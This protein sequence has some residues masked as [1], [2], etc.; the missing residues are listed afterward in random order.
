MLWMD[1]ALLRRTRI[2]RDVRMRTCVQHQSNGG[3]STGVS[4][5]FQLIQ[6]VL[7]HANHCMHAWSAANSGFRV[8]ELVG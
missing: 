2:Q 6:G 7:G 5:H 3:N 4:I 1:S 8:S